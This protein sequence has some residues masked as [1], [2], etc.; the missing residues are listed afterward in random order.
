MSGRVLL[1]TNFIS[2]LRKAPSS[3]GVISFLAR[4]E[5]SQLY[6]SVVNLAEI[7]F[8]IQLV[9]NSSLRAES[10]SLVGFTSKAV[11]C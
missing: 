1:D 9:V 2:E 10:G 7:R 3:K 11:I 8:G 5:L 6:T 4:S